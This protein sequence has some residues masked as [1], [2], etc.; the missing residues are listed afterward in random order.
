MDSFFGSQSSPRNSWSYESLKNFRQI[1][2]IVQNHLRLVYL[3]LCC[4]LG[5]FAVGTYLHILMNIGG[6]LT[7]L[8][9]L[10]GIFWL[11]SV[12]PREERKRFGIVMFVA[13]LQGATVGEF[14]KHVIQFDPS[15]LVTGAVGTAIAFGCFSA[16]ALVARRREFLFLGGL[17]ASA[18]SILFWLQFASSIF[19]RSAAM[20]NVEL[21]FGLLVFLGYIVFDT[22]YIIERA[23]L[24]DLDYVMHAL[25]LFV[26]F[27]GVLVRILAI[28]L[29]NAS[30]KSE[31]EKKRKKRS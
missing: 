16:A 22:Q 10:G 17:L 26:D 27:A 19:G 30:Q 1:T 6:L 5:S 15:I 29:K 11:Q 7:L 24:G 23:H 18:I 3:T 4:A 9:G 20:F 21:Y 2:P 8:G 28:M 14:I 25:V 12:S 13:L 31:E